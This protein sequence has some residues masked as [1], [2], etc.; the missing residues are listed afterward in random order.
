MISF[1]FKEYDYDLKELT[2]QVIAAKRSRED[3]QKELNEKEWMEHLEKNGMI[4]VLP[5]NGILT[6]R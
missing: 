6:I 3:V 2:D 5:L 1:E 4:E